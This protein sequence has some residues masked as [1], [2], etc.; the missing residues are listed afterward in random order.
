MRGSRSATTGTQADAG[1]GRNAVLTEIALLVLLSFIWGGSFTLIKIAV[2]TVPPATMVATRVA[3]AAALLLLV[4]RLHGLSMPRDRSTWGAF[5]VQ[6][7][8]QSAVPFTLITW[9]EKHIASG[10][11]GVLNATPPMFV[12]LITLATRFEGGRI[13][14]LK[15]LG[16][17]VGLAGVATVVG[18]DVLREAG[19]AVPLGHGAILG[20][21]LCYALAAM[22]GRRFGHL[23]LV[24]TAAGAMACA[25]VTMVPI[26]VVVDRPWTL[27]PSP[28]AVAAVA[29]LALVCTTLAML[30]YFRLVRTLGSLATTSGSYLR[31]GFSAVLGI[32]VLGESFEP[33]QLAGMALI[34]VGVIAV[35]WPARAPTRAG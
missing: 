28:E 8:L 14:A 15:W 11:A 18:P 12:L 2:E 7:L 30:I 31:A 9:G 1:G 26:A 17:A 35:T 6:G 16:V 23:P 29:V 3:V 25:A 13:G 33:A 27:S 20:A 32:L 24:V 4:A 19:P 21:S 5:L 10:L 34:V 22:W